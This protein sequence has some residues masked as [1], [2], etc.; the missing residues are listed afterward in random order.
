MLILASASNARSRLLDQAGIRYLQMISG[1]DEHKITEKNPRKL[2]QLLASAKAKA[3]GSKLLTSHNPTEI[4]PI[5]V[6]AIVGC[7]SI[8][9]FQGEIFGKPVNRNEAVERLKRMSG[10]SGFL[11]TGHSLMTR[12][13]SVSN[14]IND[15][16]F[17]E[18]CS[19]VIST[20]VE[21]SQ[22]TIQEIER[23]VLTG[24]PMGCAGG[25]ALEGKGGMLVKRLDGCYSNVIGLSLPWL[26]VA[27]NRIGR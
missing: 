26:R 9:L 25:F 12:E 17:H 10:N 23:Y 2:V 11:L 5:E 15:H 7:D 4:K 22:L 8:F 16:S 24:E 1:V 6:K 13:I 18:I 19:D 21:F 3:V 14:K 20:E 27:L